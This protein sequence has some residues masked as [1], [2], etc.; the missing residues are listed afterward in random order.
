MD[1]NHQ[2]FSD[3]IDRLFLRRSHSIHGTYVPRSNGYHFGPAPALTNGMSRTGKK[4]KYS[5]MD[6][7][8]V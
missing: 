5:F 6:R 3:A 2:A 7:V 4:V 8:T 1:I